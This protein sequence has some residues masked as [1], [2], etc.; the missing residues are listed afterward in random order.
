MNRKIVAKTA[1]APS[2][3]SLLLG[4]IALYDANAQAPCGRAGP[5]PAPPAAHSSGGAP[6][7]PQ[8]GRAHV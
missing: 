4:I 1:V 6:S 2:I 7:A 3:L 5:P 8:I